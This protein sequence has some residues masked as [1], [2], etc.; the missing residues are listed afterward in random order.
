MRIFEGAEDNIWNLEGTRNGG[1]G[2]GE[3]NDKGMM[4]SFT[5]CTPNQIPLSLHIKEAGI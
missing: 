4:R 1:G 2:G 3:K 5:T